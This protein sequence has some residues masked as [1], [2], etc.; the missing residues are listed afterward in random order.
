MLGLKLNHVSKRDHWY[1]FVDIDE[2]EEATFT[3]QDNAHCMNTESSYECECDEGYEEDDTGECQ[4]EGHFCGGIYWLMHYI[5]WRPRVVTVT[6]LLSLATPLLVITA[7]YG[8]VSDKVTI[9]TETEMTFWWNFVTALEVSFWELPMQ[10][11]VKISSNWH[12]RFSDD[13]SRFHE[14]ADGCLHHFSVVRIRI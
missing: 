10:I 2:C 11:V 14:Y 12:F 3:C 9:V 1:H 7:A 5:H 13:N 4:G 8:A 6:Y